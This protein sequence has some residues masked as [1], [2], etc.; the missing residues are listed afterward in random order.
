MM[1]EKLR[2]RVM[3]GLTQG[4]GIEAGLP[5]ARPVPSHCPTYVVVLRR[6]W[7]S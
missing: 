2:P 4:L 6:E 5:A 7:P 3:E 1:M